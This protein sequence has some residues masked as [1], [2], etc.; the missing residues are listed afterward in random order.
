MYMRSRWG[1][2]DGKYIIEKKYHSFRAMPLGPKQKERRA[3]RQKET[4][5]SQEKINQKY[6]AEKFTR[7]CLDNFA[8]GDSYLT[9]TYAEKPAGPE[10]VKKDFEAFKKKL[11]RIFR[12]GGKELKYISV[13]E[14]LKSKGRPHAHILIPALSVE[15]MQK[16]QAA[17]PA[18]KVRV[19]VYQGGAMDAKK[20]ME[21]FV[22]EDVDKETGSGRVMPSRNLIRREPEK[23]CVTRA[24]TYRD[25]IIPPPGYAVIKPLSYYGRTEEGYP[26]QV[27]VYERIARGEPRGK[28][29]RSI[30]T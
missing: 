6:R 22:K 12:R 20:L 29:G 30:R 21:Y 2:L 27:A 8:A 25:E 13:L 15:E 11:R 3:P 16:V 19:E 7:L 9:L 28:K 26:L 14:N 10:Q 4:P 23:T 18:G 1:S 17:W 24:E 5:L